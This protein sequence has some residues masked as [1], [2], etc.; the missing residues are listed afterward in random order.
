MKLD[1][2]IGDQL[3]VFSCITLNTIRHIKS[4]FISFS[5]DSMLAIKAIRVSIS[6]LEDS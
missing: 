3:I 4:N 2:A 5:Q 1:Q 6:A